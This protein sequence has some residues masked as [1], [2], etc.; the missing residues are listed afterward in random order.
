MLET[1]DLVVCISLI[2]FFRK[3]PF[4][5]LSYSDE[6]MFVGDSCFLPICDSLD[7]IIWVQNF[8]QFL[9]GSFF[10]RLRVKEL[11]VTFHDRL[12]LII[13]HFVRFFTA[14]S[15]NHF[16]STPLIFKDSQSGFRYSFFLCGLLLSVVDVSGSAPVSSVCGNY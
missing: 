1:D 12:A 4:G 5:V 6:F 7:G 15:F 14:S 3:L 10:K 8:N 16:G 11:S 9:N 13:A 2:S